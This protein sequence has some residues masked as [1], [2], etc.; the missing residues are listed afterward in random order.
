ML[1]DT[2][3]TYLILSQYS[4]F[5]NESDDFTCAVLLLSRLNEHIHVEQVTD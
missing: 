3:L 5:K 1:L 2:Y 4:H